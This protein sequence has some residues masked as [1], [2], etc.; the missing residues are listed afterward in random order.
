MAEFNLS[1]ATTTN[2]SG[3]VD[4]FSVSPVSL[5]NSQD[6]EHYWY[7]SYASQY[8]GYYK[9][10]P[11]VKQS[12]DALARWTVGKGWTCDAQT[13][14]KLNNIRGWGEDSIQSILW[15]MIV[16]K[17]IIG[18]SFAEIVR[19]D[20]QRM[21]NIKT[22]SP[23]RIRVVTDEK[24]LIK[25]Y[26]IYTSAKQWKALKQSDMIHLCNDRIA[27]ECHGASIIESCKWAVD[28]LHEALEDERTI[29]HRD[30]A[31][32][33][34]YYNTSNEGKITYAN[35]QIANAVNKGE[36]LGL[37]ENSVRIDEFPSKSTN[38]RLEWIKYLGNYIYQAVGVP[39]IIL[40]GA[41]EHTEAGGKVGYL[42]FEPTYASE[43]KELESDLW[44]Q[45]AIK[46]KFNKPPE[47]INS[48]Q[49]DEQ[50]NT[51]Q[52]GFQPKDTEVNMERE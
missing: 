52:T 33:I 8:F 11:E 45:A 14:V 38:N 3:V 42:T 43:Q 29:R 17:K 49:S 39:K 19:D 13:E 40:G 36:M 9:T 27:D 35:T 18:D 7:F 5:D 15:N 6:K 23:E 4:N 21:I 24:G 46:I 41:D 22:I 47:L 1:Q 20:E 28:A 16:V 44:N 2:F 25:R 30:K 51:S 34:V 10:I 50:K 12:I 31:L 32:G 48:L 26:D 37:P